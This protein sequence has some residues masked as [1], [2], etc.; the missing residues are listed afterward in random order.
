MGLVL[1]LSER[2]LR[3]EIELSFFFG[4]LNQLFTVSFQTRFKMQYV[5]VGEIMGKAL[6]FAAVLIV[7]YLDL[8]LMWMIATAVVYALVMAIWLWTRLDE[9]YLIKWQWDRNLVKKILIE[10][11][12]L[13]VIIILNTI[14]F[15]ADTLILSW[16][17]SAAEV[18]LYG[19]PYKVM[20]FIIA[21]PATSK[22]I[23]VGSL[24]F[25]FFISLRSPLNDYRDPE[26]FKR[27]S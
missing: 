1:Y 10:A 23:G 9:N 20:E 25:G 2:P 5:A 4:T 22:P 27:D 3:H 11:W 12:P 7:F 8:G 14:Y 13:G 24:C 16:Y 19:A 15:K 18:G 21:F 6:A 26:L 17:R